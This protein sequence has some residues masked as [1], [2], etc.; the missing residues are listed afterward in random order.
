[1]TYP[2]MSLSEEIEKAELLAQGNFGPLSWENEQIAAWLKEL[3]DWREGKMEKRLKPHDEL[4]SR[5]EALESL[6]KLEEEV[7]KFGHLEYED[8]KFLLGIECAE[9]RISGLP[10]VYKRTSEEG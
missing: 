6:R 9:S 5:K 8:H 2:F 3:K 7:R 10:Y 4:I 1:M